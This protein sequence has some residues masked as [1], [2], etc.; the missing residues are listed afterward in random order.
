MCGIVGWLD[1]TRDLRREG[2]LLRQMTDTLACRGPDAEG[3]WQSGPVAFGHRRLAIIDLE[4]GRQPMLAD[5]E[6]SEAMAALTFCGEVYNYR[7]LRTELVGHGHRFRTASDTEVVLRAYLQ[8]GAN[9][10]S[11]LNGMFAIGIWDAA[12]QELLLV[13]DRMGVKPLYYFPTANGV[14]FGSEPKAILANP[15]V[16]RGVDREGLCE[17]LDMVKTPGRAIFRGMH[18]VVPGEL[19]RIT[20]SGLGR[21]R[22]WQLTAAEHTDDRSTTIATVRELLED[23]VARQ[24]ISDVPVCTLLSGGL[25]SSAIT[26]I[27]AQVLGREGRGQVNSFSVDFTGAADRFQPDAVRGAADAPFVRDLA[28]HVGTRHREILLDSRELTDPAV[29]AAVLRATDVPPAFWGDMWP[30]LYLLFRAVRQQ[31]TVALSGES[32]DELFGG[33]LW[34]HRPEAVDAPT[35]PWLTS[36]SARY[37]GGTSLLDQGLLEKLDIPGYRADRYAEA[38]AEVPVLPGE[39]AEDRRLR[40][41]GYLALTRFVQTL[42]DRK[43]R[44]SMAVGLEVRVPFCDHRLVEYVFNTPWAMKTFDGKEKSLLRAAAGDLLPASILE[45]KKTPYPA[46]Q[47]P[48]YEAALRAELVEILADADAP[49]R[50]LLNMKRVQQMLDRSLPAASLPYSRGGLEMA[51]WMNRWLTEYDVTLDI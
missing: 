45:R 42:L 34:F 28:R 22:Y 15:Q 9:F 30:S 38:L 37:F 25:D 13:R 41:V 40:K 10:A 5:G 2:D 16:S 50:P 21:S 46:T 36:G 8:W 3:I 35:F 11:H 31:S 6:G 44:M 20:R 14:L 19:V 39:S 12:L 33:Y 47:D 43:D 24:L 29:R 27:A 7:E 18:E 1:F 4:G 49:I 32:A 48:Q 26:A 51:L 17:A 23:I